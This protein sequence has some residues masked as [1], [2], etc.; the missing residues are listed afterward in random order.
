MI[1]PPRRNPIHYLE[2]LKEHLQELK[3]S[4]MIEGPLQQEEPSTWFSNLVITGKKWDQEAKGKDSE[5]G[6]ERPEPSVGK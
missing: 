1:Q 3:E 4:D 5:G 2:P 6:G